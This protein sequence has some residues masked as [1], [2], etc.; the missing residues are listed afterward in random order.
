M[1]MLMILVD[2][3]YECDYTDGKVLD[4]WMI[5]ININYIC[6]ITGN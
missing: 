5:M 1:C 2:D 4:E 3:C 6:M